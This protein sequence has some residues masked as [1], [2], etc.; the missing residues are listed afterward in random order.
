ML[1]E[2]GLKKGLQSQLIQSQSKK[3]AE[4][5][6]EQLSNFRLKFEEIQQRDNILN[7]KQSILSADIS[8]EVLLE[9]SVDEY[10][11]QQQSL[12]DLQILS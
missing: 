6:A 8:K 5:M 11:Q 9:P 4:R 7:L 10:E 3:S 2:F 1:P 12:I